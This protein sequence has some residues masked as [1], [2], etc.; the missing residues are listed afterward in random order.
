MSRKPD[1]DNNNAT[2][3][4]VKMIYLI[5]Q[6]GF[7]VICTIFMC[8]GIAFLID[9]WFHVNLMI[10]FIVLGVLASFRSAYILIKKFVSFENPD[11]E[12]YK[13]LGEQRKPLSRDSEL[14]S[15]DYDELKLPDEKDAP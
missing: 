14:V 2:N 11:D 8:I 1:K 5:F 10:L 12:Y 6:V 13:I 9:K 15:S 3:Q 7:T 4:I